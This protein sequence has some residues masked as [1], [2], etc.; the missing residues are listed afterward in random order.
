MKWDEE[1]WEG[2][3]KTLVWFVTQETSRTKPFQVE[4]SV[5]LTHG[6][7][8]AM[9]SAYTTSGQEDGSLLSEA[10]RL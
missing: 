1:E 2:L 5:E 3:G 8:Q 4:S 6:P 10:H 9:T 7:A